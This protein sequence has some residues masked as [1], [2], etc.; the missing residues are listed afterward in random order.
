MYIGSY[1][2]HAFKNVNACFCHSIF[3]I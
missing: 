3:I 2:E 1:S